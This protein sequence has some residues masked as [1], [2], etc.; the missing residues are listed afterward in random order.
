M[1]T[2][3]NNTDALIY[4]NNKLGT[5]SYSLE[6]GEEK[7]YPFYIN[8]AAGLT[9][10]NENNNTDTILLTNDVTLSATNTIINVPFPTLSDYYNLKIFS[11][12][13][14]NFVLQFNDDS[15]KKIEIQSGYSYIN[16]LKWEYA[17]VIILSSENDSEIWY[18]IEE[19]HCLV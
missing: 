11:T 8:P 12:N 18:S 19:T 6:P 15:N 4:G 2:Y 10:I 1:P 16:T 13:N 3:K 17:A 7:E 9:K 14:L 5:S